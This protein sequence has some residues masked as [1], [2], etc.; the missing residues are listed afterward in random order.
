MSF[1][2]SYSVTHIFF[3][4]ARKAQGIRD[5]QLA[6]KSPFGEWGSIIALGFCILIAITKQF[7]AFLY[8]KPD[9]SFDGKKFTENFVTG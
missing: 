6:Y 3:V 7:T 9:G 1:S 2:D 5:D 8:K 4:R